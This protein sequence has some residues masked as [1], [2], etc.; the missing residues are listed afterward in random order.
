MLWG[1][2]DNTS[3]T[4]VSQ[5]SS[6]SN[7]WGGISFWK[8]AQLLR[9]RVNFCSTQKELSIQFYNGRHLNAVSKHTEVLYNFYGF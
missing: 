5:L 2:T 8:K 4:D 3:T 6:Y 1:D 9:V 7:A